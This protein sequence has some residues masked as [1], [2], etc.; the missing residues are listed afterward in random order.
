MTN[1]AA[2]NQAMDAILVPAEVTAADRYDRLS[3]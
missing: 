2:G 3:R 1:K